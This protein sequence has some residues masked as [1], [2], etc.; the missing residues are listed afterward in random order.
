MKDIS[1]KSQF[2]YVARSLGVLSTDVHIT[3][4]KLL[5]FGYI[6]SIRH[7]HLYLDYFVVQLKVQGR[8]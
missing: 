6:R 5:F 8:Y 1:E 4:V 7:D 3:E 2:I